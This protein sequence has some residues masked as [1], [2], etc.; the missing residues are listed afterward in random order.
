MDSAVVVGPGD[1]GAGLDQHRARL[2]TE[3]IDV[4]GDVVRAGVGSVGD[5]H[6]AGE[7]GEL[8]GGMWFAVEHV[9][10]RHGEGVCPVLALSKFAAV[11]QLRLAGA[12]GRQGEEERQEQQQ[13]DRYA[14]CDSGCSLFHTA[15]AIL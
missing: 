6:P 15:D 7:V 9:V 5:V 4:N 11:P 14:G 1:A 13:D 10:G 3:V 8:V 2:V 12:R